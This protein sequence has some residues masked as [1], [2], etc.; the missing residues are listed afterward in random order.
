MEI[1]D[2]D[3]VAPRLAAADLEEHFAELQH[4]LQLRA[5]VHILLC[6]YIHISPSRNEVHFMFLNK[7]V[8]IW[9]SLLSKSSLS[10]RESLLGL[11]L[12]LSASCVTRQSN[13]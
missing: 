12:W 7:N 13:H 11:D 3:T 5:Y 8:G 1:V 2:E 6:V 4:V 9:K 10:L